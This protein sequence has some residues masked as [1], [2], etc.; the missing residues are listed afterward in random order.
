MSALFMGLSRRLQDIEVLVAA[1][2]IVTP[3][4]HTYTTHVHVCLY[5]NLCVHLGAIMFLS[6]VF[7]KYM[8]RHTSKGMSAIV[9]Y[10]LQEMW[11][12]CENYSKHSN[13]CCESCCWLLQLTSALACLYQDTT[14]ISFSEALT[15][16][17]VR[18]PGYWSRGPG[19][20]PGATTFSEQ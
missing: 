16:L 12:G 6:F 3:P 1:R 8:K 9:C 11:K 7:S 14:K 13:T 18:F 10:S 2:W 20:I 19:C 17:T 15:G 5:K 4:R